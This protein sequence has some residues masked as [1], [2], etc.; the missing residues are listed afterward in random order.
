MFKTCELPESLGVLPIGNRKFFSVETVAC[1][2][3][4]QF[5]NEWPLL[6]KKSLQ[7]IVKTPNSVDRGLGLH[8][9]V[10]FV[11]RCFETGKLVSC[12]DKTCQ[13]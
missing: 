5:F 3:S 10:I 2:L 7:G 8:G 11:T 1:T 13:Y 12:Q 9:M 6:C 4:I